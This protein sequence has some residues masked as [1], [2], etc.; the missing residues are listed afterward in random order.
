MRSIGPVAIAVRSD[1]IHFVAVAVLENKQNVSL[2]CGDEADCAFDFVRECYL[3]FLLKLQDSWSLDFTAQG[4]GGC[5]APNV[6]DP[7]LLHRD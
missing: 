3:G 7:D 4:L 1:R 5:A 6:Q 2:D